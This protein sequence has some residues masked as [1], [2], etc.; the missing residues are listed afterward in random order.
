MRRLLFALLLLPVAAH[1]QALDEA[2]AAFRD[3][4][5]AQAWTIP[6]GQAVDWQNPVSGNE[7]RIEARRDSVSGGRPCRELLESLTIERQT[8]R[9]VTVGC[10]AEQGW[11]VVR[12]APLGT[13]VGTDSDSVPVELPPYQPPAD[14]SADPPQ[15][16]P[17]VGIIVR[18]RLQ[19]QTLPPTVDPRD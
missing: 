7:G 2:D 19:R 13:G 14:I 12:S 18:P 4:A 10:L 15:Q 17:P 6:I 5:F 3:Q 1:A 16:Q 11:Q 8:S 9:G